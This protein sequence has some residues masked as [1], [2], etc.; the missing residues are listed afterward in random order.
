MAP[1][2]LSTAAADRAAKHV[3]HDAEA[4]AHAL[5][6]AEA[7]NLLLDFRVLEGEHEGDEVLTLTDVPLQFGE[8]KAYRDRRVTVVK[9]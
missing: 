7:K 5:G 6:I 4:D 9:V 2:S 3:L 1:E 8:R